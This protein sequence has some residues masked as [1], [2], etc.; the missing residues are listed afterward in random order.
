MTLR[1]VAIDDEPLALAVIERF[2]G[3]IPDVDLLATF[4]NPIEAV[5]YLQ[6][7]E[8]DLVFLDIQMPDLTGLQFIQ[9]LSEA[10]MVIFTTAHPEYAAE[11][12]E[13]DA[14]DYLLKPIPFDRFYKSI[15]KALEQKKSRLVLE[16]QTEVGEGNERDFLFVKSDTRFFK[17]HYKDIL[18]V[19]GMRDYVAL[20]TPQQRILTLMSMTKMLEKLPKDD[21]MRVHKSYIIGLKHIHLIQHNR[22]FIGEKEIPVSN[23]YKEDLL[24]YIE[25]ANM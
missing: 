5:S 1:A 17:V 21:F 12:Y 22:V 11:S 25:S 16:G 15:N 8:V 20:H 18:F 13:V 9:S 6:T 3:K 24:K 4:Q 7:E 10:P 23:S 19:E 2:A 14:L